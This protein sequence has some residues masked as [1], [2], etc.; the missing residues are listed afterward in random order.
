MLFLTLRKRSVFGCGL[1]VWKMNNA[2]R[3]LHS[4]TAASGPIPIGRALES[5]VL[6]ILAVYHQSYSIPSYKQR[7]AT[8]YYFLVLVMPKFFGT[9][10][11]CT[12]EKCRRKPP[13]LSCSLVMWMSGD[14]T[15]LVLVAA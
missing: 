4:K 15:I 8:H 6:S 9:Y 1:D 7:Y 13:M 14:S 2:S 12:Y 11:G 3:F 5:D 10:V